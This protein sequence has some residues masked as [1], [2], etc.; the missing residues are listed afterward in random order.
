MAERDDTHDL[1]RKI[2]HQV[3]WA[4]SDQLVDRI[5]HLRRAGHIYISA[6]LGTAPV[7]IHV[8]HEAW[9]ICPGRLVTSQRLEPGSTVAVRHQPGLVV[10]IDA[11]EMDDAGG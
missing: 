8:Y 6:P 7:T 3:V 4:D 9:G 10:T 5:T 11:T 2:A 1:G